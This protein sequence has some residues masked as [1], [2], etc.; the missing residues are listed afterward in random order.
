M[1]ATLQGIGIGFPIEE[2]VA[3]RAWLAVGLHSGASSG[4]PRFRR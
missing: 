2:T 1:H 4:L 3:G